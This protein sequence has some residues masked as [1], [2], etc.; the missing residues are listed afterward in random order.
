M[1]YVGDTGALSPSSSPFHAFHCLPPLGE[2]CRIGLLLRHGDRQQKIDGHAKRPTDLL[3]QRNR[4]F[5]LSRLKIRKIALGDAN[6]PNQPGLRHSA[7]FAQDT[8]GILSGRQPVDNSLGHHDLA[9]GR[10]LVARIAHDAGGADILIGD[11]LG[12]PLIFALRKDC[13]LLAARSLDELNLCH[14]HLLIIDLSAMTDGDDDD[15][16]A[17]DIEDDAPIADA[18]PG[19]G[20]P[21][22]SLY[23]I[24]LTSSCESQELGIEPPAHIG[25]EIEP[26]TR[27]SGS[28]DDLH[29]WYIADRDIYVKLDIA[30]C[31]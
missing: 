12:K 6:S 30:H 7:P 1:H 11:Q 15:R 14:D 18:Q 21:F 13:E 19:A 3:M 31:D 17:L 8:D 26:P 25:G 27:G 28:K 20:A 4:T 23:I 5:A 2:T 16:A 24:A 10:D 9:A 29:G 22:E